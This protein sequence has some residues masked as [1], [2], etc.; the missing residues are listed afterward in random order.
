MKFR[1][2]YH[3]LFNDN[4]LPWPPKPQS[5]SIDNPYPFPQNPKTISMND[6]ATLKDGLDYYIILI[7]LS[8]FPKTHSTLKLNDKAI[9]YNFRKPHKEARNM[10]IGSSE[11]TLHLRL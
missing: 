3:L 11:Q 2:S 9:N 6:S 4:P 7:T 8:H 1:E 5:L 10:A